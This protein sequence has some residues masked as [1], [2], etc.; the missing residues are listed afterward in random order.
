MTIK[1]GYLADSVSSSNSYL[2]HEPAFHPR[3]AER[4]NGKK[5][6]QCPA[7]VEYQTS[8]FDFYVPYDLVFTVIRHDDGRFGISIDNQKTSVDE[9]WLRSAFELTFAE[10]GTVQLG[11]HP[12]WMFVS[13]EPGVV[14]TQLPAHNQSNPHPIR[15]QFDCYRWFRPITYAFEFESGRPIEINSN[16]PIF[17]VKFYHPTETKFILQECEMTPDI[18]RISQGSSLRNFNRKTNW[19]SVFLFSENRRPKKLLKFSDKGFSV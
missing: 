19:K 2:A 17:Q 18:A 13:D 7:I 12:F 11:V 8:A 10:E 3:R 5:T 9:R 1:I 4:P 6:R 15:G 16:S 14:L